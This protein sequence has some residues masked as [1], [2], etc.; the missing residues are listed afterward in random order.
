MTNWAFRRDKMSR[1]IRSLVILIVLA[2]TG[3]EKLQ[4]QDT[5]KTDELVLIGDTLIA[6]DGSDKKTEE[7]FM[8]KHDPRKATIRSAIIPGWGQVYNKKYWKVPIVYTAIG[9]PVGTFIYNKTWYDR[10]REAVKMIAAG[11][12]ANYV[13][14]VHPQLH[15]FF[16]NPNYNP[17]LLQYRNEFRKNMDYSVLIT[18]AMW[19]LNIIDATVDAHLKEFDVSDD[20]SL[21]V[22]PSFDA[23]NMSPGLTLVLRIK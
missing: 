3:F 21:Y 2:F 19:G 9:I 8:R 6:A 23:M 14:R 15:F 7:P 11:D 22:K 4:A 12:T 1:S 20:L 5:L 10:T 16:A 17:R 13:N 18:L